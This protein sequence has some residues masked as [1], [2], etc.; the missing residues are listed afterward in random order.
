MVVMVLIDYKVKITAARTVQKAV[1]DIE[2]N[3]SW[4]RL[5]IHA[6][7]LMKYMRNGTDGL[8]QM[9]DEIHTQNEGIADTL[10]V[11]WLA[12]AP[13]IKQRRQQVE[14][15]TSLVVFIVK[16]SQVGRRLVKERMKAPVWWDPV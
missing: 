15:S 16:G 9:W 10:L 3:T 5:M 14:I 13:T 1:I 11:P 2:E 7:P 8:Q 4:E 12:R 6:V